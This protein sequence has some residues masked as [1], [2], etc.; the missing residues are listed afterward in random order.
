MGLA[1][2]IRGPSRLPASISLRHFVVLRLAPHHSDAC[3][4][5]S[6]EQRQVVFVIQVD[7]HI[8]QAGDEKLSRSVDHARRLGDCGLRSLPDDGNT[9]PDDHDCCVGFWGS[10]SRVNDCDVSDYQGPLAVTVLLLRGERS[11]H[12]KADGREQN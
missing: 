1:I 9:V 5:I 6:D 4:A 12:H 10:S 11:C 8:P 2:F 3:Y 7:M